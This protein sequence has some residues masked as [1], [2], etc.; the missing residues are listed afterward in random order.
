MIREDGAASSPSNSSSALLRNCDLSPSEP[1]QWRA[2]VACL[3]QRRY[4]LLVP[5]AARY[6]FPRWEAFS[7]EVPMQTLA[8]FDDHHL[9]GVS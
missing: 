8:S 9:V 2:Y 3:G 5:A 6:S 4:D 7:G 1:H